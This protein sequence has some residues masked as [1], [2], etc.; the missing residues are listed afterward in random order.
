MSF[1]QDVK[2]ETGFWWWQKTWSSSETCHW[3]DSCCTVR[4]HIG[5]WASWTCHT[6]YVFMIFAVLTVFWL[7]LTDGTLYQSSKTLKT[8]GVP[9]VTGLPGL[10][11][12]C[13]NGV[14][15]V[16]NSQK[17]VKTAKITIGVPIVT[18][19]PR[20]YQQCTNRQKQSKHSQ[21]STKM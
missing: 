1:Q 10:Y 9:I 5:E 11:Q 12:Q 2:V 17:T 18:G 16:K 3:T 7:F 21:N 20:L 19:L 4:R 8:I 6:N 14:P 13:T 15:I